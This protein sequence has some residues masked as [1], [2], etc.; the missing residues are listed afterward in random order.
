MTFC[1]WDLLGFEGKK[2]DEDV[3]KFLLLIFEGK[4][5]DEDGL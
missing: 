3:C 4:K 1:C 5:E 2:K